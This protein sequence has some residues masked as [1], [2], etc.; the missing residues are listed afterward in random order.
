MFSGHRVPRRMSRAAVT[1]VTLSAGL[2]F[3]QPGN[4]VRG[5]IFDGYNANGIL[6]LRSA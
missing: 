1:P 5:N 4:L 2:V 3:R 6:L